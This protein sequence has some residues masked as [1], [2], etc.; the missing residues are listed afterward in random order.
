[1][2]RT[3]FIV[4]LGL[5]PT[6]PHC[7]NVPWPSDHLYSGWADWVLG[8]YWPNMSLWWGEET[9]KKPRDHALYSW[10]FFSAPQTTI[11]FDAVPYHEMYTQH[12]T[13]WGEGQFS[14]V[15]LIVRLSE[16]RG[17]FLFWN[18]KAWDICFQVQ[19]TNAASSFFFFILRKRRCV[20]WV[21]RKKKLQWVWL[22]LWF[23]VS[24]I[25]KQIGGWSVG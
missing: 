12:F 9:G 19:I 23:S 8:R 11:A 14:V 18:E 20:E 1:M 16:L 13:V 17:S 2:S 3:Y 15:T 22:L 24:L 5:C 21:V 25:N 6:V 10:Q 7:R 4:P